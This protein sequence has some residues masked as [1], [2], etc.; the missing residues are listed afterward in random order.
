M[1]HT[2]L[3]KALYSMICDIT[4]ASTREAYAD[5]IYYAHASPDVSELNGCN[6]SSMFVSQGPL[7]SYGHSRYPRARSRPRT[8]GLFRTCDAGVDVVSSTSI[9]STA[10][11]VTN[12]SYSGLPSTETGMGISK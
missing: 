11:G 2:V 1:Q 7:I 10:G 8:S 3:M 5:R 4:N 6:H 12:A 9:C